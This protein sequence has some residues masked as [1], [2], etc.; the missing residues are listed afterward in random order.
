M[1]VSGLFLLLYGSFRFCV[2]FFREPD[3]HIGIQAFGWMTR[4]QLLCVPLLLV[5]I[6]MLWLAYGR[7]DK[8]A[9]S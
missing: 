6:Y 2:E 5:G 9:N 8:S 4:G 7:G 1:A 3:A